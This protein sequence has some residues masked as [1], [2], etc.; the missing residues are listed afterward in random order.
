MPRIWA[1]LVCAVMACS[2]TSSAPR[3]QG[4][5]SFASRIRSAAADSAVPPPA[6]DA[7]N[8]TSLLAL[9]R[10]DFYETMH[11][12]TALQALANRDA[13]RLYL[14]FTDADSQWLAY[15]RQPGQ[16]LAR[17]SVTLLQPD[18]ATLVT[19]YRSVF[20]GAVVYDPSLP[21]T[22]LLASTAAGVEQLLPIANRSAT[23]GQ[24][25]TVYD[26]LVASGVVPTRRSLPASMFPGTETKSRKGDAY[27]WAKREWLD[28]GKANAAIL[29][30]MLD[31]YWV[32]SNPCCG[33]GAT[34]Y[35]MATITNQD[36]LI[37]NRAFLWD[38]S[39]WGDEAPVD[40]PSQPL[41]TDRTV[42]QDI[43][44]SAYKQLNGTTMIHIVGFTP[45][46]FKYVKPFGK[47]EGVETEWEY[48]ELLSGYNAFFDADAC[49]IAAMANAG[50][51]SHHALPERFV[52]NPKPQLSDLQAKGFV[53]SHGKVV[54]KSYAFWYAGDYD[55]AAWLYSQLLPRWNDT[56]RGKVPIG[57]AVDSE[58]SLR[59]PV[60]Y[61][62]LY[63]SRSALD[64]FIAGDSGAGY[65]NP[66]KLLPPRDSKLPSGADTWIRWNQA[67]YQQFDISFSGFLINGDAG[68][69]TAAALDMYT[70]FSYNGVTGQQDKVPPSSELHGSMPVFHEAADIIEP[71]PASCAKAVCDFVRAGKLQ[72]LMFR[73]ILRSASDMLA[74]TEAAQ[75]LCPDLVFVGPHEAGYLARLAYGGNNDNLAT[76]INDTLPNRLQSGQAVNVA[77]TIRNEGWNTLDTSAFA[78]Q[79]AFLTSRSAPPLGTTTL[80]LG[81]AASP[82]ATLSVAGSL[83]VPSA[84]AGA[85]FV[86]Y[87][88]VG[89]S[90]GIK[91]QSPP[92]VKA[93]AVA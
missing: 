92:Y 73:T 4:L 62:L 49:C 90:G 41:G 2:A 83:D 71:D 85:Q 61:S 12:L 1:L 14:L 52:Q 64:T 18:V 42:L 38:L 50:F 51:Y 69:L 11:V 44:L 21:A 93:V 28:T 27:M 74:A 56:A 63:D 68:P 33:G 82:G 70:S 87:G 25:K 22:S 26:E 43:M 47:H 53:D 65:L 35:E 39:C 86:S 81:S 37:Q 7:V 66:T 58:L 59:F 15:L 80:P 75:Q 32:A 54:T 24:P 84:A 29:G 13:P 8:T 72:F 17:T 40:D 31:Y 9:G 6:I 48:A 45:W 10:A 46:A 57:W 60:I 34:D 5:Q 3:S 20:Q 19:R 79:F 77:V 78:L 30:F 88:L 76:Y 67:Y 89:S 16:W 91:F 23:P 36:Y 55:S